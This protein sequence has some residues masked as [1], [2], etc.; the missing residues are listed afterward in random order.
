MRREESSAARKFR[1]LVA[2][3]LAG[4]PEE[5]RQRLENIQVLVQDWPTPR[6]LARAGAW[7]RA[8]LLGLYE[9]VPLPHRGTSYGM[10]LP[11][12]V[13]LFRKPIEARGSSEAEME[14]LVQEVVRHEIAH[15]FGLGEAR[16]QEIE[17]ER[18][19][20]SPPPERPQ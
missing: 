3:A 17:G 2:R 13:T 10:T 18:A 11:D 5:F 16:L 7:R 9:G 4:L 20:R 19:R 14:S 15:Y 6:Q 12:R 8:D 1:T